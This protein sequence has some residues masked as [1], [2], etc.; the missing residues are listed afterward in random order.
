MKFRA[1]MLLRG[2]SLMS[3]NDTRW[4]LNQ[5]LFADN[6]V[7]TADAEERLRYLRRVSSERKLRV[8]ENKH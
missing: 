7:L 1:S 4:S 6:M 5:L 8:N 2:L 3:D